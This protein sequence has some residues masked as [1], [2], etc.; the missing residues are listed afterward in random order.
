M[1]MYSAHIGDTELVKLLI[2]YGADVSKINDR[3]ECAILPSVNRGDIFVL[4]RGDNVR[5]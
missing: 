5:I 1:L 4:R 2:R 3:N